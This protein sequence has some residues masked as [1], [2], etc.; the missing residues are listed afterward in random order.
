[1]QLGQRADGGDRLLCF[2]AHYDDIEIR[3]GC[4]I[5]RAL[6]DS[7][8]TG[9]S[10]GDQRQLRFPLG[11]NEV[12]LFGD[13]PERTLA[14]KETG[15]VTDQRV[16]SLLRWHQSGQPGRFQD[17]QLRKRQQGKAWRANEGPNVEAF[18]AHVYRPGQLFPSDL[19]RHGAEQ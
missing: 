5:P 10:S 17:G 11:D 19:L 14:G 1:M 2:G 12:S 16:R 7:P 6:R 9:S 13:D 18:F 8:R 3:C 4:T 15:L